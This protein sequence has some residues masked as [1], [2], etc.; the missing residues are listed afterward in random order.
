ML[1]RREATTSLAPDG[2]MRA[3]FKTLLDKSQLWASQIAT[4][5]LYRGDAW[6]ALTSMIWKTLTYPLQTT[7][8]SR[9]E[10]ESIMRPAIKQALVA[11]G[12]CRHFP[13]TL[14]FGPQKYQGL[15]VPQLRSVQDINRL[16]GII[17]HTRNHTSMGMLY[18]ATLENLQTFFR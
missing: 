2:N 17:N 5:K 9:M 10:C 1:S 16:K 15:G 8:S 3:Q 6:T 18:R 7:S 11:M 4:S 12:Y 14:V 13:R